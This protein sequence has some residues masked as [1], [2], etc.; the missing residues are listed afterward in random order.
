MHN[1]NE[2][3]NDIINAAEKLGW[4]VTEYEDG[5]LEFQQFSPAGEDF[6]FDV[7]KECAVQEIRKFYENFDID[8]HIERW[9]KSRLAGVTGIPSIRRLVIDAEDIADMLE[10]LAFAV[11]NV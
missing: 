9:V 11:S 10:E 6:S 8:E 4:K 2:N 1:E 7:N 5:I 3:M